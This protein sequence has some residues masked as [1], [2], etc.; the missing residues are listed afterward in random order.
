MDTDDLRF[1]EMTELSSGAV[2]DTEPRPEETGEPG[3]AKRVTLVLH[4]EIFNGG[5]SAFENVARQIEAAVRKTALQVIVVLGGGN[6]CPRSKLIAQGG[7]DEVTL[8]EEA[9]LASAMNGVR[10]RR[11]LKNL[12]LDAR[13]LT[14]AGMT[15]YGEAYVRDRADH[16]LNEGCVVIL[17]GAGLSPFSSTAFVAVTRSLELS[18]AYML[19]GQDGHRGEGAI[20]Y[21]KAMKAANPPLDL[22][23]L[24]LMKDR[25]LDAFVFDPELCS[26]EDALQ[27]KGTVGT[28]IGPDMPEHFDISALTSPDDDPT[29]H[30]H[31]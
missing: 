4:G 20:G 2:T 30:G 15:R 13:M 3:K 1:L 14:A 18:S 23:S 29:P 8:D 6:H 19:V 7:L 9:T 31:S 27:G 26:I 11:L 17:A 21:W 12:G 24:G 25:S 22:A 16:L 5:P 10:L 28:M